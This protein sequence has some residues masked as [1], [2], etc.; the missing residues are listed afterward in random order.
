MICTPRAWSA[1][2]ERNSGAATIRCGQ[3]FAGG[4][5]TMFNE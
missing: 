5:L 4:R 3:G 1:A 2:S